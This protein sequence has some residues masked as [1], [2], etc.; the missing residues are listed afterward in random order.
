MGNFS[1]QFV[2]KMKFF[3]T[4]NKAE[5]EWTRIEVIHGGNISINILYYMMQRELFQSVNLG[6][7]EFVI[8]FDF[9][10]KLAIHLYH[11]L[12]RFSLSGTFI[13]NLSLF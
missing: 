11:H 6:I 9:L 8:I 2:G 12:W 4:W 10:L 3:L 13:H 5:F 1:I 7:F